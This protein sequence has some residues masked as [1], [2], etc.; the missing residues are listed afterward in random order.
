[1]LWVALHFRQLP[2]TTI[3]TV[4]GWACQ[5]TPRV[6]L[7]PP[8]A[9]LAEVSGSLRYFGGA[10]ALLHALHAGVVE[11]GLDVSLATASTARA[12]LWLAR[13]DA[14]VTLD[15]LPL[16]ATRW[17]RDFFRSIGATT[18]GDLER[19][20]R[21][22]LARRCA[23]AVLAELDAAFGRREEPRAFYAPPPRF[24][25]R[26]EL[27][28]EVRQ[29]E[30]L[31]LAARRLLVPLGGLLAARHAGIRGFMLELIDGHGRATPV[32]VNLA[33]PARDV[34]RFVR[35]LRE[36][37]A[38]IELRE[39]VHALRVEAGGFAALP[40]R[41]GNFLGDAAAEAEDWAQL[42][43]RLQ[44]R[45]G[46]GAVYGLTAVPDHR[47]EHAWRRIEPGDWDPREFRL[48]GPRPAW[49][50]ERPRR[51]GPARFELL[52]GPERIECGWWDG[53]EAKRDYF[54]ARLA[55][56]SLAWIY[57][58]DGEWFLHGLFA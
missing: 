32:A 44:A 55:P 25:A 38:A 9:L 19:L 52:A 7:E 11:L 47:P 42:L 50:L 24:D 33:S 48:P 31:V 58:E 13:A 49:L 39:P 40:G 4:A 34:E 54:V 15:G 3:E 53:D 23:S 45:L 6:S 37:L 20:P 29:A 14:P 30:P 17:E 43:E 28:A 26:L 35:L 27:P 2:G 12:A 1:M 18:L 16:E 8:D 36:R 5:F 51:L 57:R 21:A 41:S 22:G 10:E 46:R 56:A